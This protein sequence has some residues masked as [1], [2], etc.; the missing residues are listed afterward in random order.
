MLKAISANTTKNNFILL[1]VRLY[2]IMLTQHKTHKDSTF[3][4]IYITIYNIFTL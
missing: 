1:S 2:L 4:V 3:I